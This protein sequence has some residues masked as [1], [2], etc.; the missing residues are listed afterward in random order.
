MR[1]ASVCA[2]PPQ[3]VGNMVHFIT[4]IWTMQIHI[5]FFSIFIPN[6][7]KDVINLPL[8]CCKYH[9]HISA[10]SN[11]RHIFSMYKHT[12]TTRAMEKGNC[13]HSGS[14]LDI[15]LNAVSVNAGFNEPNSEYSHK[16]WLSLE[17]P[18][19]S[20]YSLETL[21]AKMEP[22]IVCRFI[23]RHPLACTL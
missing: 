22:T 18:L 7:V 16:P 21:K 13:P 11:T 12:I 1:F 17:V 8:L 19:H 9:Y 5:Y 23:C 20:R 10:F 15:Q 14:L 6:L 3:L 2:A 4:F